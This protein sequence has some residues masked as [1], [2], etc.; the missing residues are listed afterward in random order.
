MRED[1]YVFSQYV[2][3]SR[4][5]NIPMAGISYCD[6]SYL[7]KR[8]SYD[9][10]VIEYTIDGEGV[11]ETDGKK[12]DIAS[13]DTYFIYRGKPH[14]YYC[15]D[16][17]WTKIWVVVG[18]ELA[19][20]LFRAYLKKQVAVLHGLDIL[21]YMQQIIS[22]AS[23]KELSYDEIA[24]EIILNVHKILI[25]AQKQTHGLANTRKLGEAIKNYIDNNLYKPLILDE[26]AESLHYSKNHIIN[27]FRDDYGCTPYAYYEKQKM[28]IASDL[29]IGSS[30]SVSDISIKLGFE[31]P[32]YFSKSFKKHF[33][34]TPIQFRKEHQ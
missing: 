11:F 8:S 34:V 1:I 7:V 25:C 26:L 33:G 32:Q 21:S 17:S 18:G 31:N 5:V 9:S 13:G 6:S 29:L 30:E 16:K 27:V 3:S 15:K 14:K 2:S 12:Y 24:D 4:A 10:Y 23:N 22:L 28:L 19:D 20:A